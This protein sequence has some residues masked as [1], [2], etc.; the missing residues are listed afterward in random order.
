[1][2]QKSLPRSATAGNKMLKKRYLSLVTFIL[3]SIYMLILGYAVSFADSPQLLVAI[4]LSQ[5]SL[6][7]WYNQ[8][9]D[10][11]SAE[12]LSNYRL[13]PGIQVEEARLDARMNV[14]LLNTTPLEIGKQYTLTVQGIH[15]QSTPLKATIALKDTMEITF[16]EGAD[17][18]FSGIVQDTS[19]I[20]DAKK[21]RR[22]YNA[23]G[24]SFLR[25]T[26]IGGVFFVVF[27]TID[28]FEDIGITQPE[29]ILD[30][31]ISLYAE[32]VENDAPQELIIRRVLLPWKEGKQK[33]QPA[34]KNELTFNSALH[35]NL[36]W[37]KP[38]AQ[39][40]LEG[41]NGDEEQD[42]NGSDDVAHRIDAVTKI[43]AAGKRHVWQG[44]LVTDA[45]RFW[46]A[47]PDY[48]Y[49]YIFALRDGT[50]AVRFASK[51]HQDE[52]FRPRLT[53]RYKTHVNIE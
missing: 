34:A 2:P 16:G 47:N 41:V 38:P 27:K 31:S 43:E 1:M 8:K 15:P 28:A 17:V 49:G 3:F 36:P 39:A 20:V 51:E 12:N 9:L 7:L 26:P 35:K 11:K 10:V 5:T 4:P 44:E 23:G 32:S 50:G 19:L 18:T 13:E 29:Q 33:S 42:Y 45:F 30:A 48:N 52:A 37:N 24:E 21:K 6:Q 46:L 14:V 22:N 25:C 53:I 40:M